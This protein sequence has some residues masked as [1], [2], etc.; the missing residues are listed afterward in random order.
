MSQIKTNLRRAKW[1]IWGFGQQG[2][3]DLRT[4]ALVAVNEFSAK[5]GRLRLRGWVKAYAPVNSGFSLIVKDGNKVIYEEE[6]SLFE[7]DAAKS[8]FG[9]QKKPNYG[10]EAVLDYVSS[11]ELSVLLACEINGRYKDTVLGTLPIFSGESGENQVWNPFK[12]GQEGFIDLGG[13]CFNDGWFTLPQIPSDYHVDI[14]VPVFNGLHLLESLVQGLSDTAVPH[15]VY[16]VDDCSTDSSVPA[17]LTGLC[18]EHINYHYICSS[19]NG[20]FVKSVNLG[21]RYATSDVVLL[22]TDVQLPSK[23]LERLIAPILLDQSVASATP[24]T[25]SGTICSFPNFCEDNS[26]IYGLSLNEIDQV[27]VDFS[28]MY[29]S[30]PTGVGF[31]MACSRRALDAIGGLDEETFGRG[32]G[33]ENDWCQRAIANGF[34][35]VMVENLFVFHNHGGSFISEEK[36]RL[37]DSHLRLLSERYPNY[38]ADV[39]RYCELNPAQ[40][41]R[42]FASCSL[43]LKSLDT[44]IIMY[45]THDLG[46]GAESYLNKRIANDLEQGS[47]VVKIFYTPFENVFRASIK[48]VDAEVQFIA[49]SLKDVLALVA[50]YVDEIVVNEL[51]LYP[52]LSRT[53]DTVTKFVKQSNALLEVLVHDYFMVCPSINLVGTD[54]V[55]CGLPSCYG[56]CNSCYCKNEFYNFYQQSIGDYRAEWES[57]LVCADKV[58][59]F[60]DSSKKIMYKVF[61]AL[62]NIIVKPHEVR[63]LPSV[64]R[65]NAL[66]SVL[67]IGLLGSLV[68]HKG[69]NVVRDLVLLAD[70]MDANVRFRLIGSSEKIKG[71]PRWSETGEYHESDLPT[72]VGDINPDIFFFP[73]VWPE[74]FS[75]VCSEIMELGY[76]LA[77]FDLGAQADKASSVEYG[78]VLPL[79]IDL[80]DLL[81]RLMSFADEC[82]RAL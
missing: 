71:S 47:A 26:L 28:P 76:P 78:L 51:A 63:P 58:I 70:E 23:W 59:V 11:D 33:E 14:V 82:R 42:A 67:T 62:E 34:K 10:I 25:N 8:Y 32:Y 77:S 7:S 3:S 65:K 40:E 2:V 61:P 36:K 41:I 48:H 30:I 27:F 43:F 18:S 53:L 45:L 68:E 20:G 21:L 73:S 74:T 57:L 50:P 1:A 4:S 81:E 64:R 17:F 60:S 75:Y 44:K 35:N 52:Q 55:Y 16:F 80:H 22:N 39:A 72:L 5:S 13:S 66:D 31:C 9:Y 49:H 15:E 29:G 38:N 12:F 54:K 19:S 46:G 56:K 79:G 6:L 69:E 37:I 24:F